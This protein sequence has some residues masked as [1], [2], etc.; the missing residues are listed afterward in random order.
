MRRR[1]RTTPTSWKYLY[2]ARLNAHLTLT[3]LATAAEISLPHLCQLE[4][5]EVGISDAALYRLAK[6]L[7]VP[8]IDL[9]R[10]RPAVPHR[11]RGNSPRKR[12]RRRDTREADTATSRVGAA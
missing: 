12:A 11:I 10:S 1:F 4:K 2:E 5:G 3:E 6:A 7:D 9:D 8:P